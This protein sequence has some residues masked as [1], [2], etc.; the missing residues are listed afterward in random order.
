MSAMPSQITG[1]TI[2]YSIV[3]SGTDQRKHQSSASLAKWKYFPRYW[4]GIHRSPVNSLHKGQ[5]RGALTFSLICH[6]ASSLSS[7]SESES[8]IVYSIDIH[9]IHLQIKLHNTITHTHM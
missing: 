1:L 8:V 5:R 2:V 9:R 4:R 7:E 3:Y 6:H